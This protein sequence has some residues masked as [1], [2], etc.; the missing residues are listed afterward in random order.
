MS[1]PQTP[2]EALKEAE[3]RSKSLGSRLAYYRKKSGE[4]LPHFAKAYDEL[5]ARLDVLDRGGIGPQVGERLP[6]FSLPDQNGELVSLSSVL[7]AGPAIISI[8]RGHWCPYCKLEL[9][10]LA[11]VHD[12]IAALGARVISIM[13]DSAAFTGPY[14]DENRLPFPILSD[15][16][17]G[18][19]LM[20][21][22]IF[23][24]GPE[25]QRLY[26]DLGVDLELYHGNRG[27]FLP[28]AA[29]FVV[30]PDGTIAARQVNVEF[31]ERMEPEAML[32]E[33]RALRNAP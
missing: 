30:R 21:G 4:I 28:I 2:A 9:R 18:Y 15:T 22:L 1:N 12:E 17:L 24:I 16:D 29:K 27:A 14:I 6:A 32:A 8:N 33:L 20:L 26:E 25:V 23:W 13:P 7:R 10:T 19:S 11:T 5:V 3:S 31:R